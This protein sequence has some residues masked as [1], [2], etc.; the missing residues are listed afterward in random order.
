MANDL[1][2][3]NFIGRLGGDPEIRYGNDGMCFA[4]FNIAV[5]RSWK[6]KQSGEKKEDT[7]WVRV[8]AYGKTAE[9]A[10]EYLKKGSQVHITSRV[11]TRKWQDQGGADR[12][13]TEFVVDNMQMLGSRQEGQGQ[14]GNPQRGQAGQQAQQQ[15]SNQG[16]APQQRRPAQQAAP[17]YQAP[18]QQGGYAQQQYPQQAQGSQNFTPDLNEGWDDDIPFNYAPA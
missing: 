10:G 12:Y 14:Q 6:D 13:T 9:I 11:K 16:Q 18:Q 8:V 3:C 5:G 4:N 7:E 15:N 1:N 2:Q 17:A